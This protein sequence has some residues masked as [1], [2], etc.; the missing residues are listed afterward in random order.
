M[1]CTKSKLS[2]DVCLADETSELHTKYIKEHGLQSY[3][4]VMGMPP[5]GPAASPGSETDDSSSNLNFGLVNIEEK[6]TVDN[7]NNFYGLSVSDILEIT[8]GFLLFLYLCRLVYRQIM[9]RRKQA[10]ASKSLEMKEIVKSV[11]QTHQTVPAHQTQFKIQHQGPKINKTPMDF[12]IQTLHQNP[13]TLL[14]IFGPDYQI[15]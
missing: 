8:I 9:R 2:K 6:T 12:A 7:N 4:K 13:Q 10:K 5:Q 14:P 15:D 11:H 1:G 3:Y